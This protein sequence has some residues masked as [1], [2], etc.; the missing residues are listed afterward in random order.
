M[1]LPDSLPTEAF[2]REDPFSFIKPEEF[3]ALGIDPLDIPPGTFP[4]RKHPSHLPSRFGGNAYGFGFFEVYDRLSRQEMELIHS[5]TFEKPEAIR[6]N[7]EKINRIYKNMGLLIRFSSQ[8]MPYYLIP[9]HLVSSSLTTLKNKA[10]EISRVIHFHRRKYL[11]ER[12]K[13][14]LFAQSDDLL[15]NDLS[16]RFE[17]H[18]FIIIDSIEK[19]RF[20]CET[21]DLVIL[22]RDIYE[23]ILMEKFVPESNEMLSRKQLQNYAIYMLGK[24]YTLL[25]PDGELFLIAHRH[26]SRTNQS[27]RISFKTVQEIKGFIL[28]SHIFK[29]RKKYQAK[30]KSL[31]VN[32]FDFQKYL[33]GFYVE[34]EVMDRLLGGRDPASTSLEE[35]NRLP[36]LNFPLD[37][38]LAYDQEKVWP[39]LC[40]IYFSEILLEPLIPDSV[41]NE[42]KGKFSIKGYSPNYMLMYLGQK[43]PLEATLSQLS[44]DIEESR[45]SGCALPLLADYRDSF[46]YLASVLKVL[47]RVKR[48]RFTGMPEIFMARLRQP[49]E[50]K[51][52]RYSAVNDVL[53]LM[54]KINRLERIAAY[55]NPDAIEGAETKVLENLETFPFF[56]F[57]YGELREIFLIVVGHTA[58]GRIVSGK[59][60][61]KALKPVSDLARSYD[62]SQGLNL[63]RYCRLMSVAE[64]A[65]S[66]KSDLGQEQLAELFDLYGSMV[67]VVTSGEMDW[68]RLLDERISSIGGIHNKIIRKTLKMMNHFQFLDNWSEL[69]VKGEMEKESLADYDEEKLVRI[70]DIIKLVRVI[71]DFENMFLKEDPLRLPIFYRKFLNLEFHGTGHLFER[72]DSRLAFILLWITV[73]VAHGEVINF[74][75]I[76]ADVEPDDIDGRVKKVEEEARVINT[77]YLDLA[78]LKQLGEQLYGSGTSFILGTGF[79][80]KVNERTQALEIT[81]IDLDE[82]I[83]RLESLNKEFTGRKISE[84]PI[85]NLTA[86]EMLFA[87]L[88]S[89]YQ[90]H[91]RVLSRGDSEFKIPR[92]QEGWFKNSERLR[93]GLKSNFQKVI[94]HPE[95]VYTD[96]DLLYRH[97]RSLL[98]FV[99]PELMALQDLK[100]TGK[101]YLKSPIIDHT[102]ASTR[103]IEALVRGDREGFQDAQVLHRLAQ[104]EFGPLASGTVGLN[105]TQIETLE[106]LIRHLSRNQLLFDALI[107]SFIFRDLGLVP[108]LREKY[109]DEIN[110][111][112]HAQT[113]ALFLEREKIPLRYGMDKRAQE[114]L[115]T[116]VRYHDL[117]HHMIRGEFSIYAIQEVIDFGDREMFDAF[118]I[119]SFVMFSAMR[120]D[121]ILEDLATRL[122]ELRSLSHRIMKGDTT[123][124]DRLY[125]IYTRRGRLYYAI[126]EYGQRGLPENLTPVEYLESWKGGESEGESYVRA[127]RMIYAMERIFRLRG[128][129]YVEFPDLA[130]LLL[131]VPLKFIYKKRS[132]YGIGYASF[133]RE[134]FEARRI[135]NGLQ[136]LP[137]TI[138]HFVLEHLVTDEV[139]IFGF[140]NVGIYLNYENLIKLLLIAL[141]G[142]Q[143]FKRDQKPVRLNFLDMTEDIDK[144]YEAVN[145]TLSNIS[146]EKLWDNKYQLN[147]FFKA[148]TGLVMKKDTSQRVLSIDFVDK[149]N[150]PQKI[151]YMGTIT[152]VEQLKNYFHHSL[153]SLRKSP[154]YTE[155]YELQLEEAYDKRLVEITDLMLDQVKQQMALLNELK[156]LQNLFS[157]LMDRALEIGFT[158]DQRNRLGDLYEVRK[159]QIRREKL[160]EISALIEAIHD[161]HEL[162]DYWDSVKWYLMNN[163]PFLGKE[164]EN[165]IS[166]K[167]DEA[168]I[169]LK[170]IS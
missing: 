138:R 26:A 63:L 130:N 61:E 152:D 52:R 145:D 25:K 143:K 167:F 116:L 38:D 159:D 42:W 10:D 150:V 168:A 118:F 132:Y 127:G 112:D 78:T 16:I 37:G 73:N 79:Q 164:F 85:E 9:I 95:N 111:A 154:L 121:L 72:M 94:F 82:N 135:Y 49:L 158:D 93:E 13:I 106:A 166:K 32:I 156:E 19:L 89:F 169:R 53:R 69:R 155:D 114:Y 170:N 31:L 124:E 115:L 125:E 113:G 35:I 84:I 129:R 36:Y 27:A 48:R 59:M 40:S 21:L 103:K 98:G 34:Q 97:C 99:L 56:G 44:R 46:D 7:S 41:R 147:H 18:Q 67:R 126:E 92:R 90:S 123:L 33:S 65:A 102:L 131:K 163:R 83:N 162:K 81:Y 107:K 5:I 68:D 30:E 14:G 15:V 43:K 149:I 64:T 157:D 39:Q 55:F 22:P 96:L 140:E 153:R 70:E 76:L 110:P 28:F 148:K 119:S 20:I 161:T 139:R 101:I 6:E 137:A 100:L 136:G 122:F 128:I 74:N 160:D 105:E 142:S 2:W 3:E 62:Q 141:L 104:R 54:S 60:N 51:K 66:Q 117:L 134:L 50:N 12:H 1:A 75:P 88:E 133:E 23:I 146:V 120:E 4:A 165:L 86:L 57:T 71:E 17:E 91:L 47:N 109:E 151:S 58:M 24:I 11:K 87:N 108:A 45:L 80:L 8:G 29:T 144:R 77:S